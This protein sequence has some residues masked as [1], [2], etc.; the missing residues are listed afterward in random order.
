[1]RHPATQLGFFTHLS[2]G[3]PGIAFSMMWGYPYLT[4]GE[5]LSRP[6]ASSVMSF[7]VVVGIVGG[8]VIGALTQR[9]PLRRSTLVLLI[10]ATILVPLVALVLW[11]GP[12][13]MWL[14]LILVAGLSIGGPGSNVGFDFPRTDLAK[15]RLGTATGVVLMGGF[16]AALVTI[17][18][19]G[20]ILDLLRPDGDYDLEAFRIAF[21]VQ[22]P[23]LLLGITG[24]LV[25]RRR[26]RRRMA[27]RGELV[28]PWRE[29]FRDGR[30]R[31][32]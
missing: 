16:L 7:L 10:I 11:P 5:G 6:A 30:W 3:F 18:L 9:H 1:M 22:I 15:H 31:R 25:S 17:L 20:M 12:A 23:I 26:L 8:P 19:I 2:S 21:A 4:A 13:P 24:M 32:I 29:V 27:A 14:L 28:P